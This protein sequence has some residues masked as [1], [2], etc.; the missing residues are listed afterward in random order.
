MSSS[1]IADDFIHRWTSVGGT[2]RANY[3]LFITE[4]CALLEVPPPEQAG[5]EGRWQSA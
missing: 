1:E 5:D 4:L 2:E 3:Q